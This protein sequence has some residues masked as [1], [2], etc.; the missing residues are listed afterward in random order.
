MISELLNQVGIAKREASEAYEEYKRLKD[1]EDRY[2]E[3]LESELDRMGLRSAKTN[4]FTATMVDSET[5]VIKD[6]K[7]VVQWIKENLKGQEDQYIGV[8]KPEF[9][10]LAKAI[11][12]DTNKTI[13][14]TERVVKKSLRVVIKK[15]KI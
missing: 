10:A 15:E 5:L 11:V 1:L 3:E 2:K 8:K 14:G 13:D 7:Q 9:N 4:F 12:K 6:E